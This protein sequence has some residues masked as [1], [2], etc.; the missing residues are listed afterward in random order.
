M[1]LRLK[2]GTQFLHRLFGVNVLIHLHGC[3]LC[4]LSF[5]YREARICKIGVNVFHMLSKRYSSTVSVD[6]FR[7][8]QLILHFN[9]S[10]LSNVSHH[11]SLFRPW[12]V[13]LVS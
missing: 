3:S 1:K 4:F 13:P 8:F 11:W 10:Y 5:F 12:A 6:I 2:N 7:L 9:P